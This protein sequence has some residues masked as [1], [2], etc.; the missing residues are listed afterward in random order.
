MLMPA[1]VLAASALM[2]WPS[3]PAARLMRAVGK[4]QDR[5][6]RIR[7]WIVH[8]RRRLSFAAA[9]GAGAV[10]TVTV[11]VLPGAALTL[12]GFAGYRQWKA[13]R[14]IDRAI[15]AAAEVATCVRAVVGD[16]NAGAPPA[17]AV[18]RAAEDTKPGLAAILRTIAA[19]SR[20]GG[21]PAAVVSSAGSGAG[22]E[23]IVRLT[24]SWE[25]ARQH[26]LPL[27]G[28]LEAVRRDVEAS[29]RVARQSRARMAGPRASAAILA[30]LPVLGIALGEVMGATPLT[31]LFTTA[32]G[33]FLLVVGSALVLGGVCWSGVLTGRSVL[34]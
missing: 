25:L 14:D 3:R 19:T 15:Q 24:R 5:R 27:A 12:L 7:S 2:C 33:Q 29:V 1:L 32:A 18:E 6:G 26:G 17:A 9:G 13:G 28:V 22:A 8:S 11:G 21:D 23:A 20:L 34:R 10:V 16:L 4:Q 31:I 30:A